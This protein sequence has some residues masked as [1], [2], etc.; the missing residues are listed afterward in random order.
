MSDFQSVAV[1]SSVLDATEVA[2]ASEAYP[3]FPPQAEE[4]LP[5]LLS[6]SLA[7]SAVTA[8]ARGS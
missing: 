6:G 8:C 7:E 1:K 4:S 3:L 5:S 2:L